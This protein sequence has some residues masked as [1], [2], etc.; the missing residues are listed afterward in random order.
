MNTV[1]IYGSKGKQIRLVLLGLL[2]FVASFFLLA[3]SLAAWETQGITLKLIIGVFGTLFFGAALVYSI[4]S[5]FKSKPMIIIDRT[6]F[7]E[8]TNL[9]STPDK[10]ILWSQVEDITS[11]YL[12]T[13]SYVSITLKDGEQ[14]LAQLPSTKR[15]VVEMNLGLGYGHINISDQQLADYNTEKLEKLMKEYFEKYKKDIALN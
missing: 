8:S 7:T 13:E 5:L 9:A 3:S 2:M 1:E 4:Y 11:H 6:G 14:F 10:K 15:K 12:G